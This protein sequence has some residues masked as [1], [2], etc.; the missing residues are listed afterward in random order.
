MPTIHRNSITDQ[1]KWLLLKQALADNDQLKKD[2]AKLNKRL[3]RL[4]E[5]E[6]EAKKLRQELD[7]LREGRRR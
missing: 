2:I 7:E 4:K 3:R 1:E 6:A 5:W